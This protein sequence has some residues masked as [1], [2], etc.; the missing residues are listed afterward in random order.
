[1]I[2]SVLPEAL[3]CPVCHG[4]LSP[5]DREA[6]ACARCGRRY[7]RQDGIVDFTGGVYYDT[8]DES[9]PVPE[10]HLA[11][12]S[13]EVEGSRRRIEDFYADVLRRLL[14]AGRRILDVGCGN[15][16]SV[17][18]LFERGFVAWGVDASRLRKW[19]WRER[20]RRA[21]LVAADALTLPFQDLWFDAVI[22]SGVIEHIGVEESRDHGYRVQARPDRDSQRLAFLR[23]TCRVVRPGGCIALDFP[24]GR[25]PIDFWHGD[26]PG[27]A[28]FHSLREGFLPTYAE[29]RAM[30]RQ[31][32][33]GCEV[34]ALSPHGRLQFRQAGTHRYGRLLRSPVALLFRLMTMPGLRRLART[35]LNPFLVIVARKPAQ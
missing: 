23:E 27:A 35:P 25:F 33:P 28:R 4:A 9:I 19:Q 11:G 22:A 13:L 32:M 17:D 26:A 29:V 14:P 10:E 3:A 2:E 16:I 12:L 18:V 24:N 30:L 31:V 20:T 6:V 15:G 8:F 5:P 7:P 21:N 34:L 1:V